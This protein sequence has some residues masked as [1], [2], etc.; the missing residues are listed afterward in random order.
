MT[1]TGDRRIEP[2]GTILDLDVETRSRC[3]LSAS[4]AW[5]YSEDPST[6]VLCFQ[7]KL[8][9]TWHSA[10]YGNGGPYPVPPFIS[11][12][13]STLVVVAHNCEFEQ[14]IWANVLKWPAPAGWIDTMALAAANALPQS[15]DNCAAALG[16]GAKDKDGALVMRRLC[17]P[18]RNGEYPHITEEDWTALL[19][20]CRHDVELEAGIFATLGRLSHAEQAVWATH[21]AIN[22]R[23]IPIDRDLCQK[24]IR[25]W[26]RIVADAGKQVEAATSGA[27]KGSD[28]KRVAFLLEWAE[29]RGVELKDFTANTVAHALRRKSLPPDVRT[30]LECRQRISRSSTAK[31]ESMLDA[32]GAD[33]RVRGCFNYHGAS[34]GR[35]AGRLIQPQN[36]PKAGKGIDP[37]AAVE[38]IHAEDPVALSL[39]GL[40]DPEEAIVAA[41]RA[42]IYPGPDRVLVAVDYAAIEAR[43]ALWLAEDE[44]HLEAYRRNEDLYLVMAS[45]IF[46]RGLTKADKLERQ[47]GKTAILGC[48]YGMGAGRFAEL[49]AAN[50]I[51]LA[52]VGV[53]AEG[54]IDAYRTEFS[55]LAR[56]KAEDGQ[57]TGLWNRLTY[58]AIRTVQTGRATTVG[59]L[60]FRLDGLSNLRLR[61]PSGRELI[62][63]RPRI[64][65]E[66]REWNGKTYMSEAVVYDDIGRGGTVMPVRAWGGLWLEN[67]C[68]ATCRELLAD[69]LVRCEAE[70]IETVQHCHDEPVAEC[71]AID[72]VRVQE[73]ME[74]IMTHAPSW[75]DGFPIAVEGFVTTRYGKEAF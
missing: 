69:A 36:L 72:A 52:A 61:L 18:G 75:A 71:A 74:H 14:A 3:D 66:E 70:G 8:G 63:R 56:R 54:V 67:A 21:N 50:D 6:E 29:S 22:R 4:G 9:D 28:L 24:A 5:R 12:N 16:L 7:A 33:G 39:A 13:L 34:T 62:Y 19:S 35:W 10:R 49:C 55:S 73:R 37:R 68:Q 43:G 51:D 30:V 42:A 46:G 25:L 20:Y 11:D 60:L 32:C 31:F 65:E 2:I 45:R 57:R 58:G 38:A 26:S 59:R 17:K 47:V 27:V 40:G 41:V 23:G 15:L 48:G 44:Y 64:E 1:T 53:T